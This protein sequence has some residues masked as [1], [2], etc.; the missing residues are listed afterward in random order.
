MT[1]AHGLGPVTAFARA[2]LA[3]QP[4]T[5][6]WEVADALWLA[7]HLGAPAG[8][9]TAAPRP[10]EPGRTDGA[11]G[12]PKAD[13]P[14]AA[15]RKDEPKGPNERDAEARLEEPKEPKAKLHAT[16]DRPTGA[17]L[18]KGAALPSAG[19]SARPRGSPAGAGP[20]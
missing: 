9:G 1:D 12:E 14:T 4:D 10:E 7:R 18:A 15:R 2:L 11:G 6:W 5:A 3:Q 20:L 19:A 17:A 8:A 13:A 16:P